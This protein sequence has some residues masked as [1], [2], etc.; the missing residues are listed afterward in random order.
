MNNISGANND[1]ATLLDD[2][3][4]YLEV[5]RNQYIQVNQ[6]EPAKNLNYEEIQYLESQLEDSGLVSMK[7]VDYFKQ[8]KLNSRGSSELR[9]HKTYSSYLNK[10]SRRTGSIKPMWSQV[11]TILIAAIVAVGISF[12]V[13]HYQIQNYSDTQYQIDRQ[14]NDVLKNVI[15]SVNQLQRGQ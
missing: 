13:T 15:G 2:V 10:S 3:F 8:F 6:M 11:I 14:Q 5:N 1:R 9:K 12:L 7:E 4:T